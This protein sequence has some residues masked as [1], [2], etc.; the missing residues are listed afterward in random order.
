M[1]LWRS[2]PSVIHVMA[3]HTK[4]HHTK[5]PIH[6]CSEVGRSFLMDEWV[7]VEWLLLYHM[8]ITEIDELILCSELSE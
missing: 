7:G 2:N 8:S 1:S 3:E 4:H 5:Y 6:C